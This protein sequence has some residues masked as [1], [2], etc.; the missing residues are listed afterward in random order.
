[1]CQP[2]EIMTITL[3]TNYF[4]HQLLYSRMIAF[5]PK[6]GSKYPSILTMFLKRETF[7][8]L[9]L[10]YCYK[11]CFGTNLSRNAVFHPLVLTSSPTVSIPFSRSPDISLLMLCSMLY[12][13]CLLYSS[14]VALSC[15]K[16][17]DDKMALNMDSSVPSFFS[18]AT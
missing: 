9:I 10:L 18:P 2:S 12:L 1:M 16:L 5:H 11:H 8:K 4:I 15:G 6:L 14:K 17:R 7:V 3:F 13:H